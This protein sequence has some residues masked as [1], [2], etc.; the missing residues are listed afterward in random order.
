MRYV[1]RATV[2]DR[3]GR[4]IATAENSYDKTHP[5]QAYFAEKAGKPVCKYLHAEILALLRSRDYTPHRLYV[6]RYR[7]DGSPAMAKPCSICDQAIK[8]WGVKEVTYTVG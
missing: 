7:K 6:E 3:R 5:I 8:A 1:V 2:Y 4:K